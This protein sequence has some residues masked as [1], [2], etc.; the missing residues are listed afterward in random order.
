[1]GG[2]VLDLGCK[3]NWNSFIELN[4]DKLNELYLNLN[5]IFA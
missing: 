4:D 3:M 2:Y 5:F 1:M